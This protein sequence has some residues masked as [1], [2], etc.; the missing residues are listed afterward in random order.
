MTRKY[1]WKISP[2][3]KAELV[4]HRVTNLQRGKAQKRA[5]STAEGTDRPTH[6]APKPRQ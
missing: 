2:E 1:V 4:K 5:A 3:R 6:D